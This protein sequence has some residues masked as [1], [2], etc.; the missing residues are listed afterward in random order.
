MKTKTKRLSVSC[1]QP[2]FSHKNNISMLYLAKDF[3][4]Q[5]EFFSKCEEK[6]ATFHDFVSIQRLTTATS[7]RIDTLVLDQIKYLKFDSHQEL[8][9]ISLNFKTFKN[10][11]ASKNITCYAEMFDKK[12][13]EPERSS[14]IRMMG[15]K[16]TFLEEYNHKLIVNKQGFYYISCIYNEKAIFENVY[17][18]ISKNKSS[19]VQ[20]YLRHVDEFK[21][22]I[23]D[24]AENPMLNDLNYKNCDENSSEVNAEKLNVLIIVLDSMSN[25]HFKRVFPL[26]YE[27]LRTRLKNNILFNNFN[28]VGEKTFSNMM[29]ML[30]GLVVDTIEQKNISN[31]IDYYRLIDSTYHDLYPFIWRQFEKLEYFT[32]YNEDMASVGVFNLVKNGFKYMP[33]HFYA[34]PYWFKY[35]KIKTGPH[36]CHNKQPTYST[37]LDQIKL[38]VDGLE[39]TS[40]FSFNF[41]K[42]YTHNYL[43]VP[44]GFDLKFKQMLNE[45]ENNGQL[46]KTM[47]LIMGDH[48]NRLTSYFTDTNYGEIEHRNPF[49]SIRLPESLWSSFY[50]KNMFENQNKLVTPFDLYKTLKQFFYLNKNG[51]YLGNECRK[52]FQNGNDNIR[53]LRGISL[54]ERIPNNRTCFDS[55]VPSTYCNCNKVYSNIK[56][57]EFFRKTNSTLNSSSLILLNHI[58][59]RTSSYREICSV[60]EMNRVISVRR[61]VSDNKIEHFEFK[62]MLNPNRAIFKGNLIL[63]N[64]M[65]FVYGDIK[66]LSLYRNE[67]SCMADY[68]LHGFCLCSKKS[69]N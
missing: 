19:Q 59:N 25:N 14:N 61:V 68:A 65:L 8:Y 27:Y 54:L 35:H 56:N 26:T 43:S 20:S 23:N 7:S 53:S 17:S 46:K 16:L 33:T 15:G 29:P 31:E 6:D 9:L 52:N 11:N 12:I 44:R 57:D 38:L 32:S 49:L 28:V 55:M 67:S 50:F 24:S 36:L 40:Y 1:G 51:F 30:T 66:R 69:A 42:Y 63:R 41:L 58:N 22:T 64:K 5:N 62:I 18:I 3:E 45:F 47:L 39:E 37:S 60:Y 34:Q 10:E 48:G 21:A 13:N 4:K 2:I